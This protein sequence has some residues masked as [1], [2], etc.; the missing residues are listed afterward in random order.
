MLNMW[1]INMQTRAIRDKEGN[2]TTGSMAE[3]APIH[4]RK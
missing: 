2:T 3:N 4:D 1:G